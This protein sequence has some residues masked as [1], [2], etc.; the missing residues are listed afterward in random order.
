MKFECKCGF[1]LELT[2]EQAALLGSLN[3]AFECPNCGVRRK[4]PP[5]IAI[6]KQNTGKMSSYRRRKSISVT[7]VA[8]M[9]F[10]LCV[11]GLVLVIYGAV[12]YIS[13][14][15]SDD[16]FLGGLW[17]GIGRAFILTGTICMAA[18]GMSGYGVLR[19]KSWGRITALTV[20]T[21]VG[22][23]A[24]SS[25]LGGS[26]EFTAGIAIVYSAFVCITLFSPKSCEEFE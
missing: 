15:S 25:F 19:R 17:R 3:Q 4:L 22:L 8:I 24:V 16:Q 1:L 23:L 6:P 10:I 20:A 9:N 21:S 12:T 14:Q 13:D 5:G 2:T 26:A 18:F 7:I 11:F